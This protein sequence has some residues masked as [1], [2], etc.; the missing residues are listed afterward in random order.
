[1]TLAQNPAA[2]EHRFAFEKATAHG[3]EAL[4]IVYA[5]VEVS[6]QDQAIEP[7]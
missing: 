1:M 7:P 5:P 3:I 6:V 2:G 4:A